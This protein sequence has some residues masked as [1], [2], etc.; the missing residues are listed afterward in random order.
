M[1]GEANPIYVLARRTLLDAIEALG[2]HGETVVLIGAQA[3]YLHT[4]DA[5]LSTVPFTTDADFAI[6][7]TE[8]S[9]S[10]L[11]DEVM[12]TG[13]FTPRE[14]PGGWKSKDNVY[15]SISS[16]QNNLQAKKDADVPILGRTVTSA[17]VEH[18]ASRERSSI[19]SGALSMRSTRTIYGG[20]RSGSPVPLR[21]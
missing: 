5:D 3:I 4:G 13:G 15:V 16:C 19:D 8:L 6:D 1:S 17:P 7:P 20:Q 9:D 12:G 2:P 11:I 14:G 21:S 10:P 18:A